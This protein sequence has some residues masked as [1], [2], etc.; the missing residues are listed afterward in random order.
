MPSVEILGVIYRR[1]RI[2]ELCDI[3]GHAYDVDLDDLEN[4]VP[5]VF[6]EEEDID[7]VELF[8]LYFKSGA[9]EDFRV[10]QQ[11]EDN[12]NILRQ[13]ETS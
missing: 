4:E 5:I 13:L 6:Y 1:M 7:V 10:D 2:L 12:L 8:T 11:T 3:D 9:T